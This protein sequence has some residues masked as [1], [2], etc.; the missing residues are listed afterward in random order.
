MKNREK[1]QNDERKW[2]KC[3]VERSLV[4]GRK[5]VYIVE[6]KTHQANEVQTEELVLMIE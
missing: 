6:K 3:H 4:D 1:C 5:P 2:L